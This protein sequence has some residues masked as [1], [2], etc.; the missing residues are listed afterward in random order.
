DFFELG[1]SSL[2]A[3]QLLGQVR[4]TTGKN[5]TLSALFQA[6]TVE[7]LARL[8]EEKPGGRSSLA[9]LQPHG[10]KPPLIL[11]HGAGGGILWGYA[12]L[13]PHLGADQPVYAIE[14]KAA[15]EETPTVQDLASRYITEL[16][17][18]QPQGPY[19]LGG[20]CFGG[21]VAYEMA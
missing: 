19:Q 20:Y 16:R 21:Y 10:S 18:L 15:P 2:L 17:S 11:V 6:P 13:A 3:V 12:N 1:G 14:P 7:E 9:A 4:K 8:L 5:I